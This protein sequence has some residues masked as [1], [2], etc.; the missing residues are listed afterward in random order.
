MNSLGP[1]D[2]PPNPSD[3]T[4]PVVLMFI[5]EEMQQTDKNWPVLRDELL[6]M[7]LRCIRSTNLK[8]P[9]RCSFPPY[10][11]TCRGRFLPRFTSSSSN[12]TDIFTSLS[13]SRGT[14]T[15][16]VRRKRSVTRNIFFEISRLAPSRKDW[17]TVCRGVSK[18]IKLIDLFLDAQIIHSENHRHHKPPCCS[19]C[20]EFK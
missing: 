14:L 10:R 12:H 13:L 6:P 1:D 7:L 4:D 19:C 17:M 16:K 9:V 20:A 3:A 2:Q 11:K 8:A 15:S 18:L 5:I